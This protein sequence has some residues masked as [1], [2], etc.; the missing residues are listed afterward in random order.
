MKIFGKKRALTLALLVALLGAGGYAF[1]TRA[2]QYRLAELYSSS[3]YSEQEL[4]RV[5]AFDAGSGIAAFPSPD[6]VEFFASVRNLGIC[7]RSEVRLYIYRYLTSGREYTIR[8]LE[9]SERYLPI[10][11]AEFDRNPDIPRELAYLPLLES[12]FNPR[13]VSR[14]GAMGLWQF[15]SIT[16][17]G[18]GLKNDAYVDERRNIEKSTQAAI[19]H[20]RYLYGIYGNWELALAAYNGG[21]NHVNQGLQRT[22]TADFWQG[23]VKGAFRKETEEYVP[24]FAALLVI[25]RNAQSLPIRDRLR[26]REYR[27]TITVDVSTG[28]TLDALAAKFGIPRAEIEAWNPELKTAAL[29]PY[30]DQYPIRIPAPGFFAAAE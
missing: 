9:Q 23:A 4:A 6:G 10:I 15:V 3:V 29:P 8:A 30:Q 18:L 5:L 7:H 19:R 28:A 12:G 14:T 2:A 11:L 24:K 17:G 1:V 13:A 21:H 26:T 16:A 27:E 22:G 20:L 25:A